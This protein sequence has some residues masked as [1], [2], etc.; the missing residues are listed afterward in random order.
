MQVLRNL[1]SVVC[2]LLL[3]SCL[4]NLLPADASLIDS[5]VRN[6]DTVC[7]AIAMRPAICP[8]ALPYRYPCRQFLYRYWLSVYGINARMLCARA[9]YCYAIIL[10][11]C[12]EHLDFLMRVYQRITRSYASF[13]SIW[14]LLK[15]ILPTAS[16]MLPASNVWRAFIQLF[17]TRAC[18]ACLQS[19]LN[20][21][22]CSVECLAS[23]YTLHVV[24]SI[25]LTVLQ[26]SIC[27]D[28]C[29]QSVCAVKCRVLTRVAY[30]SEQCAD[31]R[32][33]GAADLM[34]IVPLIYPVWLL[35]Q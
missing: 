29:C 2:C 7:C 6:I 27:H 18:T 17:Y 8:R 28:D 11:Y 5:G 22:L 14:H 13:V 20:Y 3:W 4:L 34:H 21:L 1:I 32:V 33:N 16:N 26:L 10:I 19:A 23:C 12:C 9:T 24:S 31:V 15:K 30:S 25:R 35:I